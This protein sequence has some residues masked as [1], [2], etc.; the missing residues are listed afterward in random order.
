MKNEKYQPDRGGRGA[1]P[2]KLLT[3]T[4]KEDLNKS[5]KIELIIDNYPDQ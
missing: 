3:P 2:V 4:D 5:K 1:S